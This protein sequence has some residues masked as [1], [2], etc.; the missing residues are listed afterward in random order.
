M[1]NP[2]FPPE[3][4]II[5]YYSTSWPKAEAKETT[6]DIL[7]LFNDGKLTKHDISEGSRTIPIEKG[8]YIT[9]KKRGLRESFKKGPVPTEL[10]VRWAVEKQVAMPANPER[11]S[12]YGFSDEF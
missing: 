1:A 11:S 3:G 12:H 9:L 5:Y 8:F 7:H 4:T 10:W 6:T 2:D